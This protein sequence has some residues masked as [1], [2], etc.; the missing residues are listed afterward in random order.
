[1]VL[2]TGCRGSSGQRLTISGP[3]NAGP[4]RGQSFAI[5]LSNAKPSVPALCA[6]GFSDQAWGTIPLP[7]SLAPLGGGMC[8]VW[9]E[10][11]LAFSASVDAGG[12]ATL[13]L[14]IANDDLLAFARFHAT[15]VQLDPQANAMG[16]ATANYMK[17]ILD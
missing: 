1:M 2:G 15:W 7:L 13:S 11:L 3:T 5:A 17:L 6:F 12:S 10:P 8:Q 14:P 9:S 16:V 4:A